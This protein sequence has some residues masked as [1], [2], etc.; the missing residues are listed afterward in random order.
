MEQGLAALEGADHLLQ[1]QKSHFYIAQN[2]QLIQRYLRSDVV[3]NVHSV[4]FKGCHIGEF[5]LVSLPE[6]R[7]ATV[8]VRTFI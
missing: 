7:W 8:E 6:V 5:H 1:V 2:I 4:S 3:R